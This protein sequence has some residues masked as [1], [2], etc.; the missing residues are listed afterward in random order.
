MYIFDKIVKRRG[1]KKE[2]YANANANRAHMTTSASIK[3]QMSRKY[4]PGWNRTPRS[5]I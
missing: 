3:F 4:E 5:I 2:A 1:K